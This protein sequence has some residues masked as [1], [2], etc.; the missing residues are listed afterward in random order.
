MSM[1]ATTVRFPARTY[2]LLKDAADQE[3]ISVAHFV[4][5]AALAVY[6]FRFGAKSAQ[7]SESDRMVDALNHM[8]AN[9]PGA[10]N[11]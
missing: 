2:E 3:G 11:V 4:R 1:K 7:A 8:Q 10:N 5:D 6:W 9:H